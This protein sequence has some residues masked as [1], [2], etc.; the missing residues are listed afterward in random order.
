M[1][2]QIAG[3]EYFTT[4]KEA[5]KQV[6]SSDDVVAYEG[7]LGWYIHSKKEYATNYRKKTF[8]FQEEKQMAEFYSVVTKKKIQ[9][10]E[11]DIRKVTKSGRN[12][13]VGKYTAKGKEYEAWR[14]VGKK[15]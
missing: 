11:K 8:G 12:F 2:V 10:P 9:I 1:K 14:I 7:G 6:K 4:K 13:L 15:K 3:Y 5:E